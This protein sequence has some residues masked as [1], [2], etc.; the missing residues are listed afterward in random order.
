[1]IFNFIVSK[2]EYKIGIVFDDAICYGAYIEVGNDETYEWFQAKGFE[3]NGYTILALVHSLCELE[4]KEDVNNIE[5]EAEADN[6]WVY[7]REKH[8]IDQLLE[9]FEE[10]SKAEKGIQKLI[11]YG[12]SDLLE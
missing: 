4:F 8:L 9:K 3:G 5:M 10:I 12:S 7:S 2:H 11:K 6:T 1:M